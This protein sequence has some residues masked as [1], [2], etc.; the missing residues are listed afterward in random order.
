MTDISQMP[1]HLIR[2]L[3]Q[4]S[5]SVFADRMTR[6]GL[7]FTPVQFAAL[8]TIERNP[9][10]D[11][12]T[13]AGLIAYDR[14]TMGGVVDRL[15]TKQL[16]ARSVSKT[17]RRAR[18]LYLTEKG[19]ATLAELEP[20]VSALQADILQGLDEA[21]KAQLLS[22]LNKATSAGNALSRAPMQRRKVS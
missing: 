3:N 18:Q 21:E 17:D 9:G 14:A 4:I 19:S 22:L 8:S 11:Q 16:L 5:V 15:E 12:A 13:L 1:G 20:L 7:D 10:L 6:A 2:R